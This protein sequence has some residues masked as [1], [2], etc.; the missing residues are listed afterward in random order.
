MAA[1]GDN[2]PQLLGFSF[3]GGGGQPLVVVDVT[4]EGSSRALKAGEVLARKRE[5]ILVLRR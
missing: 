5:D 3:D 2:W 4:G 1:L